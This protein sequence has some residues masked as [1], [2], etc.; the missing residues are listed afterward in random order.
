MNTDAYI[1]SSFFVSSF[2][3]LFMTSGFFF[4]LLNQKDTYNDLLLTS[5]LFKYGVMN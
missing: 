1:T 5:D 4:V 3:L 2:S